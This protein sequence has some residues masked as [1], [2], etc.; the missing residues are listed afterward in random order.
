MK[1]LLKF[2]LPKDDKATNLL[3]HRKW[4]WILLVLCLF[5][6]VIPAYA[7]DFIP[8]ESFE[9]TSSDEQHIFRFEPGAFEDPDFMALFDVSTGEIIYTVPPFDFPGN[10]E[11]IFE[12]SFR[13]SDDLM[14]F[15]F[16]PISQEIGILFYAEGRLV[17]SHRI[18][19]LVEDHSL[20]VYTVTMADWRNYS[21]PIVV[22]SEENTLTLETIDG[23]TYLFDMTT[24]DI[25]ESSV[26]SS[27]EQTFMWGIVITGVA[28]IVG[29]VL[30]IIVRQKR[31]L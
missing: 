22:D 15:G 14:Y 3:T 6:W 12:N 2:A 18:H 23:I 19:D 31:R 9:V 1:S 25:I 8:P 29:V 27:Q 26:T 13:F 5:V 7:D 11:L 28:S 20:I 24:G 4:S 17:N 30:V 21:I 10:P 16:T